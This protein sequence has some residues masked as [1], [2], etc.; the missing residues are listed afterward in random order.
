VVPRFDVSALDRSEVLSDIYG[1]YAEGEIIFDF[2]TQIQIFDFKT[3]IQIFDFQTQ[4]QIFDSLPSN[5]RT[6]PSLFRTVALKICIMTSHI[7]CKADLSKLKY[8][9]TRIWQAHLLQFF[10]RYVC[11]ILLASGRGGPP[12]TLSARLF[13]LARAR[14]ISS[15]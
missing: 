3:Q 7:R 4:I 9:R 13:D 10:S 8:T 15:I 14:T 6:D 1:D 5:L 12:C 11:W 2:K